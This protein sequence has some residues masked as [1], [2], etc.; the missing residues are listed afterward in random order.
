AAF[1]RSVVPH[2][3]LLG[4]DV[5]A[6]RELPGVVAV[7]TGED[8]QTR[9]KATVAGSAI[10]MDKMPGIRSPSFW[11]LAVGKLRFVGDPIALVVAKSRYIAED[12]CELIVEDYEPLD[13]IATYEQALDPS[14][15]PIFEELGD[16]VAFRSEMA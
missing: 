14:R 13:A 4:V 16:N 12:A 5:S 6:A 10:G 3:R 7:Y 8:L 11:P 2:A 9:V 15:P 1:L